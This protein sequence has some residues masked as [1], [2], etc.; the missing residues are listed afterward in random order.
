MENRWMS[1]KL[2]S[3]T[4]NIPVVNKRVV[5]VIIHIAAWSC[6]LMLPLVFFPRPKDASFLPEQAFTFYFVLSNLFYIVFYYFNANLLIPKLLERK[7]IVPYIFV[8]LALMIFF[9]TFPRLY[10]HYIG[11]IQRFSTNIK[12]TSLA[13]SRNLRPSILSAGSIAIFLLVFIF[14]T[15]IK[16]IDQWLKAEQKNK[17]IE[18]EKLNAELSFLKAQIN[19]HFLF[20][21]LNNIYS[22]A[23]DKSDRTPDAVMK[24]ASIMRYVLTEAKNDSVSLD[25]EI[26]FINDYIELQKMRTTK[27]TSICFAVEGDPSGIQVSP[28][29][30]LPLVENAFKYGISNRE[31]SPIS[32]WMKIKD[33]AVHFQVKNNKHLNG[34]FKPT[35]NTGIGINN[36]RR[37][38]ELLYP[39]HY[40]FDIQDEESTYTANLNIFLS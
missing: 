40:K 29:V 33:R 24:L 27:K 8:I 17:Q 28:L 23:A 37:R 38:L 3:S 39:D 4:S 32:I 14:S 15:A 13:K 36:T 22:L 1:S 20:N 10:Q 19:P 7:K 25:R 11:D 2:M 12:T 35:N 34:N 21:T 16:L 30:F 26:Q 9:G 6:F 5:Q 31:M 18:N